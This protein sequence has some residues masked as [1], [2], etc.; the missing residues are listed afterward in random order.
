ML[1]LRDTGTRVPARDTVARGTCIRWYCHQTL[2]AWS[3]MCISCNPCRQRKAHRLSRKIQLYFLAGG[4]GH[5]FLSEKRAGFAIVVTV[6]DFTRLLPSGVRLKAT[7]GLDDSDEVVFTRA[8]AF[9]TFFGGSSSPP[10][11]PS[12]CRIS[13][14]DAADALCSGSGGAVNASGD[15]SMS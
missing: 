9:R 14:D 4:G 12:T 13:S 6:V 10:L 1:L 11:A 2:G 3:N 7:K 8:L 15:L 5:A